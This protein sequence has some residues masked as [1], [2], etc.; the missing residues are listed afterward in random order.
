MEEKETQIKGSTP[1]S[2]ESAPATT[3]KTTTAAHSA[4]PTSS[5]QG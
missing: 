3:T 1:G 4:T 2:G 5:T